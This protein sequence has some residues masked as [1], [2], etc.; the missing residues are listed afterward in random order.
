MNDEKQCGQFQLQ[1]PKNMT[2]QVKTLSIETVYWLSKKL[3][4][5]KYLLVDVTQYWWKV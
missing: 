5:M 3:Q 4:M 2:E 1:G